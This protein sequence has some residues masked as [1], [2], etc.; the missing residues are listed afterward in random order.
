MDLQAYFDRIGYVEGGTDSERLRRVHRAHITHIPFEALDVYNGKTLSL[1]PED[2]F[3]KMVTRG[4]GGYCFEMNGLFCAMVREMGIPIYGVLARIAMAPG[5][6]GAHTHRMNIAEADG[7]RW[8]CDVGYGGDC[9]TVPLRLEPGLEQTAYGTTY[10]IVKGEKVQYSVQIL[11]EEGFT[12]MLGFDDI[13][14]LPED[15]ELSN[16][17]TNCH[18]T[19][20]FRNFLMLNRFTEEGRYSLFN[21][22]LNTVDASGPH[23]REVP[24]EELPRVLEDC[25]GLKDMPDRPPAP[26]PPLG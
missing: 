5:A 8:V 11:R 21:L 26:M 12:D 3:D 10:R 2:L 7:A 19:S 23:R 25:F 1:K 16:F 6:F 22:S 13:P 4:R 15:F 18:P 9:F 17:Y 20:G 14:A 24:W